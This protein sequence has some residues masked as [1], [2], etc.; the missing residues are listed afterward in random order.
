[1]KN[2]TEQTCILLHEEDNTITALADLSQGQ[3]LTI[4]ADEMP[5]SVVVQQDIPYAHK[6][7]RVTIAE[8]ADVKKYGE[9]IG[10]ATAVIQPGEHVHVHNVEGKRAQGGT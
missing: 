5:E 2:E 3:E 9:V 6:F 4:G 7:A 10:I 8:G 1:M